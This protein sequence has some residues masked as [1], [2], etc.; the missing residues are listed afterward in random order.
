MRE[1]CVPAAVAIKL[2]CGREYGFSDQ[3]QRATDLSKLTASDR[4][5]LPTNNCISEQDLSK[6]DKESI[7]SK[8]CNRKFRAKNIRN[9]MMLYKCK[10]ATK[11]DRVSKRITVTLLARE[12]KWNEEQKVKL[13]ARIEEKLRKA[14]KQKAYTWKLLRDCKSWNGPAITGE[15][16]QN[17]LNGKDNQ[18]EVLR[19]EMS[20]YVHTHKAN[21]IV[22][23]DLYRINNISY[24]EMLANLMILLDDEKYESTATIANLPSNEDVLKLL[25]R[26]DPEQAEPVPSTPVIDR[27]NSMCVVVWGD[28]S[29]SYSWFLGY[30]KE[31]SDDMFVVDHLARKLKNSDSKWKYPSKG[32]VQQV[33]KDQIV[34]CT[35]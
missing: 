1:M 30:I 7:V 22:N 16:L 2:Q 6:F 24:E 31:Q 33:E 29:N 32:D 25:S 10:R 20:Y 5:G 18:Q 19:T 26:V 35:I 28:D 11:I 23:K 34:D 27:T 15:E 12:K 9:N 21:K 17:I 4:S 13:K 14:S 3:R 8:C